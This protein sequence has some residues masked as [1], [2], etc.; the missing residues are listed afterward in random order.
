[1]SF[2]LIFKGIKADAWYYIIGGGITSIA[3]SICYF[4]NHIVTDDEGIEV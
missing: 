4:A 3:A 1:M 2:A